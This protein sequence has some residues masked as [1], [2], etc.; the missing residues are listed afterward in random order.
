MSTNP[1]Q[2][3]AEPHRRAILDL[4][5]VEDRC[6]N[7]LVELL[8]LSQ[9]SV[10]RHLKLL[11]EAGMVTVRTDG[12]RRIYALRTEPLREL[13]AWLTPYRERWRDRLAA[14]EAHLDRLEEP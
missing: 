7:A 10:S 13:D 6:V 14:L 11:R 8:P 1:F 9:P 2:V 4:L 5:R 3:L 12:Q